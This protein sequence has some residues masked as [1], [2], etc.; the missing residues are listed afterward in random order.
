MDVQAYLSQLYYKSSGPIPALALALNK[1]FDSTM[2][3]C[4]D[5]WVISGYSGNSP[6]VGFSI[7]GPVYNI[8]VS[9]RDSKIDKNS[10]RY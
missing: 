4:I 9:K 5:L 6:V 1:F 10:R 7:A 8:T 3:L 2:K